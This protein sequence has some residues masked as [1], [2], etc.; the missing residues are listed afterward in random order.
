MGRVLEAKHVMNI[1]DALDL[2]RDYPP[3][4]ELEDAMSLNLSIVNIGEESE[5]DDLCALGEKLKTIWESM[6]DAKITEL[7]RTLIAIEKNNS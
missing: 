4:M 3:Y 5:T 2:I 6:I 7:Q 1:I